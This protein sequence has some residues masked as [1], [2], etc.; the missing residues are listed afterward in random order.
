MNNTAPWLRRPIPPALC[1]LP[2]A[3]TGAALIELR[4]YREGGREGERER[5][6]AGCALLSL[7]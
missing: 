7:P 6:V 4:E 1:P 3:L 5:G 2:S